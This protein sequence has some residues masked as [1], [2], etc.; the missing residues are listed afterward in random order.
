MT[1]HFKNKYKNL[2]IFNFAIIFFLGILSSFSLPPYNFFFLNF[3]TFPLLYLIIKK[4][5]NNKIKIFFL[6]WW[7]GFG[8]FI[9]SLYWI[10]YSLTFDDI[11]KPLIPFFNYITTSYSWDLH[12]ISNFYNV[13]F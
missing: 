3:I 2:L 10:S 12:S 8:Y 4:Y 7:F 1:I 6:G 13:L 11:F 5:N 9:S